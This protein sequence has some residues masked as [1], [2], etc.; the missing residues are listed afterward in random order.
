MQLEEL[1]D[2]L[3]IQKVLQKDKSNDKSKRAL[4]TSHKSKR[5]EPSKALRSN[6]NTSDKSEFDE[7]L[8]F[9]THRSKRMWIKKEHWERQTIE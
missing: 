5:V 6:E 2:I 9:I 7:D 3:I 1:V 8:N 4:K